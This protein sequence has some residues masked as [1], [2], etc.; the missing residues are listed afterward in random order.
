MCKRDFSIMNV[1]K[2]ETGNR[3]KDENLN[4]IMQLATTLFRSNFKQFAFKIQSQSYFFD[5]KKPI[6]GKVP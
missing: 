5:F 4:T 6:S 2:H 1:N 3:L